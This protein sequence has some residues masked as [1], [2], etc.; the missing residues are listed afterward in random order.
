MNY[1]FDDEDIGI[2]MPGASVLSTRV[3]KRPPLMANHSWYAFA[4]KTC[5][6]LNRHLAKVHELM[7]RLTCLRNAAVNFDTVYMDLCNDGRAGCTDNESAV[8][9]TAA[10]SELHKAMEQAVP[11]A[12]DQKMH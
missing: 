4:N 9:V 1:S 6:V 11:V 10:L 3:I 8:A 5:G 12:P 7:A 2:I